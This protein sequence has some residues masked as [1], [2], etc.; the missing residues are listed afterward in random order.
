MTKFISNLTY[1]MHEFI[2]KM[3]FNRGAYSPF[4]SS[5]LGVSSF[6]GST[7]ISSFL[8]STVVSSFLISGT[9]TSSFLGATVV[10]TAFSLV[11]VSS[12]GTSSFGA[13]VSL[14]FSS[15]SDLDPLST[16]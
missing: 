11:F 10:S 5:S 13:V 4:F 6:L 2:N 16:S 14:D 1:I 9:V 15:A 3:G 12:T 7:V 8:G